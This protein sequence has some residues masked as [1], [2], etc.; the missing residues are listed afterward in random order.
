MRGAL[1]IAVLIVST[2][3]AAATGIVGASV[4][5]LGYHGRCD[6]EQSPATMCSLLQVRS[7]PAE[8]LG[9]LIPPSIMLIVMGPVLEVSGTLDLFRAAFIPGAVLASSLPALYAGS[10]LD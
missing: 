9:I 6:D 3:F 5:L 7:P 10:L 1:F 4:T 8:R 2:I